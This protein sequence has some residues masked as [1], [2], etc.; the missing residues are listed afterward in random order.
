MGRLIIAP[1]MAE[2][3]GPVIF[4]AG[5]IQGA[6]SWHKDAIG[7]LQSM[8]EHIHIAS[9]KRPWT[10]DKDFSEKDYNEQVDWETHFLRRAGQEGVILFWLA[11]ELEHWCDRAYAQTTRFEIGEWKEYCR[12]EHVKLVIGIENG[13]TG[14]K[15]I[16]RRFSQDCPS[17]KINDNLKET[18]LVA[19]DLIRCS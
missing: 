17:V 6:I 18:C 19:I 7:I 15:Y 2:V 8:D 1:E 4:L 9:P 10:S 5:P 13:F 3:E 14:G 16:R 11:R 12:R